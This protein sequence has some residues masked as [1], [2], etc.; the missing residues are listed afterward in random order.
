[1]KLRFAVLLGACL[2]APLWQASAEA[3][4]NR[5]YRFGLMVERAAGSSDPYVAAFMERLRE[6]GDEEG[7]NLTIDYRFNGYEAVQARKNAEELAKLPL[8]LVVVGGK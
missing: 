4:P 8:D 3:L 1:M 5:T 2:A 6:R 7:R